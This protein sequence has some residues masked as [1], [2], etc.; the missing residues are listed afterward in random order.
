M[1][2]RGEKVRERRIVMPVKLNR[3]ELVSLIEAMEAAG[4][5]ATELRR[6][7]ET[8][9]PPAKPTRR[10]SARIE[11]E[12]MSVEERLNWRVGYLF[13]GGIPLQEIISYDMRFSLR[14]LREKSK[15]NGISPNGDKKELAA[16]L[17]AHQRERG[18]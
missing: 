17:I 2:A 9:S 10:E 15:D 4:N 12:E 3:T 5:D 13:P 1:P 11:R 6:E 18:K 16:K 8:L 14:E 7:L